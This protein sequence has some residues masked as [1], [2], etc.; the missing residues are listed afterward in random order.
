MD[1]AKRLMLTKI[2]RSHHSQ[3]GRKANEK[4][5]F[6]DRRGGGG[7]GVMISPRRD[8]KAAGSMLTSLSP[9][10][11]VPTARTRLFDQENL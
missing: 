11:T 8:G 7:H 2:P 1:V 4:T 9:C 10:P 3:G 5:P 6:L